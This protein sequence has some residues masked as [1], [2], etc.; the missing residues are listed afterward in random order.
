MFLLALPPKA[1]RPKNQASKKQLGQMYSMFRNRGSGPYN[2]P[3]GPDFGRT[4]TGKEPKSALRAAEGR[5]GGR[6]LILPGGI[7][8]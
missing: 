5:L 8:A 2:R 3:S 1:A 4:A 7:I 6:F